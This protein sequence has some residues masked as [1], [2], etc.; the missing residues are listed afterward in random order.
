[1]YLGGGRTDYVGAR[2]II[3]GTDANS[4][5]ARVAALFEQCLLASRT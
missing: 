4:A 3:N 2:Q 5:I 1:M